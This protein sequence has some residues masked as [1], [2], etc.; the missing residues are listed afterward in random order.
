[1]IVMMALIMMMIIII[2]VVIIIFIVIIIIV[3]IF[4]VMIVIGM[5]IEIAVLDFFVFVFCCFFFFSVLW[6]E[7]KHTSTCKQGTLGKHKTHVDF[8][9]HTVIQSGWRICFHL[10]FVD[11]RQ[12]VKEEIAK[13]KAERAARVSIVIIILLIVTEWHESLS[14][15]SSHCAANW[16]SMHSDME[17]EQNEKHLTHCHCSHIIWRTGVLFFVC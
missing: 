15:Q 7:V 6:I 10:Y 5:D 13:D 17:I 4:V 9:S 11:S 16:P 8:Y 14:G 12:R 1:M 3:F 2:I